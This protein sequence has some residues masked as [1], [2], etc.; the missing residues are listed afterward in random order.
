MK[1]TISLTSLLLL[2]LLQ[3]GCASSHS[4]GTGA[5]SAPTVS[6]YIDTSVN[7]RR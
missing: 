1:Y 6:G 2:L 5:S 7:L 3:A 4:S